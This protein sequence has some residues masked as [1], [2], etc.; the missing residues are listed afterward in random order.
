MV[1]RGRFATAFM[2]LTVTNRW[3]QMRYRDCSIIVFCQF[4]IPPSRSRIACY[5]PDASDLR[6][7]SGRL[8]FVG[9]DH[10]RIPLRL[11]SAMRVARRADQYFAVFLRAA[12][13]F[14]SNLRAVNQ[15]R[16]RPRWYHLPAARHGLL[17]IGRIFTAVLRQQN[18]FCASLISM[19]AAA[20]R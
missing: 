9:V 6:R 7:L 8:F 12:S 16:R 10:Q 14:L 1:G 19:P 2:M 15:W 3:Q 18:L 5:Q 17:Q 20:R 13:G 4:M 11:E